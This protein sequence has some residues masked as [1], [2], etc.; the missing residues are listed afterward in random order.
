VLVPFL[1]YLQK[2]DLKKIHMLLT[3]MLDPRFND[4][5]I[6]SSYVGIEKATI[7]TTRYDFKTLIPFLYLVY[8]KVH[9]FT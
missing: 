2:F 3:L 6:L 5:S 7:V 1:D 4:L 9:Q 8:Q